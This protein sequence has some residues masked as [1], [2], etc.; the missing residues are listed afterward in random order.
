MAEADKNSEKSKKP[1]ALRSKK[2]I[3]TVR[4]RSTQAPKQPRRLKRTASQVKVPLS[5]VRQAGKTEYHLPL[6]DN[7]TGRILKKRVRIIPKFVQEA[8]VEI[9]QVTWPGPKTTI[10]LT[11]AVF[12]FAVVFAGIVGL[13]DYGL[14]ELF[15]KFFVNQ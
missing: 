13:L 2:P 3:Q 12:I 15:K 10:R 1:R 4:E 11:M 5:R 7:K 6:P 9:R 14:G 8:F